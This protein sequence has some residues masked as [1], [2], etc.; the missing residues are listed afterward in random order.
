MLDQRYEQRFQGKGHGR[1]AYPPCLGWTQGSQEGFL[2][3]EGIFQWGLEEPTKAPSEEGKKRIPD[4]GMAG[5]GS[6]GGKGGQQ[7]GI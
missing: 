1:G 7:A 4:R 5:G 6:R 3:E 2:E